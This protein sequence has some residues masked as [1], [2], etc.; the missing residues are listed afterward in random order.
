MTE[1]QAAPP[2][3]DPQKRVD[4]PWGEEVWWAQTDHYAGKL[5]IVDAG[6]KLSVQMHKEKDETSYLLSGRMRLWQGPSAEE[7]VEREIGPGTSW[8]NEPGVVHTIEAIE[9]STVLEVST[10]HLDDVVR[11]SDRYGR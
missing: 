6:Q 9:D 3:S 10:P 1:T 7:L 8:R 11:L 4:K 5:L 2:G